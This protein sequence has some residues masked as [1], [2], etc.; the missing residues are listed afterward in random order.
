[1]NFDRVAPLYRWLETIVFGRQLQRARL[2]FV[3]AIPSPPQVLIVGE[4]N[5]RFLAEFVRAHPAAAIDCVE[6][7]GRMVALARARNPGAGQVN[8]IQADIR[9]VA[10]PPGRYD[11]LVTHFLLDC[12]PAETLGAVV[13]KLARSATAEAH[14]LVADFYPP[15]RGWRRWQAQFLIAFMYRFFALA[16]GIEARTLVDYR[17]LLRA[18]G[19]ALARSA[20]S[21]NQMIR[22]ECWRRASS[23][24]R[25]KSGGTLSGYE[26]LPGPKKSSLPFRG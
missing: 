11:L 12:F 4:G 23:D 26:T 10:L 7:S 25:S 17:P 13:A 21:P 9:E 19:F 18:A 3:E 24:R 2:A 6:A 14:W 5:G 22:S 1:M 8:F 16:A 20:L 15:P